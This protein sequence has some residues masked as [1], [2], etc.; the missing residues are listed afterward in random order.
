MVAGIWAWSSWSSNLRHRTDQPL[1]CVT[2]SHHTGTDL[3]LPT[4]PMPPW[5]PL[6]EEWVMGEM[7]EAPLGHN[8]CCLL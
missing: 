1:H 4:L 2:S 7:L 8:P 5:Q 3:V 6:L